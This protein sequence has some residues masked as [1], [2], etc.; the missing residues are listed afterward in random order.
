MSNQMPNPLTD[1]IPPRYRKY[2]Y[3]V[4]ALVVIVW[5]AWQAS[6]GDWGTFAGALAAAIF[7][8]LLA[9]SN[10]EPKRRGIRRP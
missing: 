10:T 3:A 4:A 7:P 1:L 2:V 5:G 9:A 8:G 6:G